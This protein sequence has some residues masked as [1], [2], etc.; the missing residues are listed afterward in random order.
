MPTPLE[1]CLEDLDLPPEDERYMRCVAL[2]GGEPG[3]NLDQAGRVR[4]MPDGPECYELWVSQ[5]ERLALYRNAGAGPIVVERGGRTLEAP[6]EKPVFLLDQDLLR[7]NGRRL[8]VHVHGEAEAVYA[9][10]P[11]SGSAFARVA[12]AAATAL[13][14]GAAVGAG[15]AADARPVG[16][17]GVEPI[18]VRARPPKK[19]AMRT[20][21]CDI[22][23][24]K[25]TKK[26]PMVVHAICPKDA[27]IHKGSRG[28]ILDPKTNEPL[29]DGV[30][31]VT[32]VRKG[33]IQ[34]TA[35][36]LKAPV[37]ATKL[38]FRVRR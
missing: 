35:A 38:R 25:P 18:E 15:S 8:Q 1:I 32:Q 28:L 3:L 4:W 22:T 2:P 7:V 27:E 19:V 21:E 9:P 31:V 10:E 26:G 6:E 11:L 30:V 12:R 23:A 14:L 36:K 37:K 17:V 29:K 13:A 34:G 5:D 16:A 33:K 20:V 24:M